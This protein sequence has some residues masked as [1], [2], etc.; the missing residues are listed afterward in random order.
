MGDFSHTAESIGKRIG[1]FYP[2]PK[3]TWVFIPWVRLG[4][5]VC[6]H[7]DLWEAEGR[8]DNISALQGSEMPSQHCASCNFQEELQKVP[9]FLR[10][11]RF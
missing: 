10:G 3:L 7:T 8:M 11:I 1:G 9:K 2:A 5:G 6:A 4:W